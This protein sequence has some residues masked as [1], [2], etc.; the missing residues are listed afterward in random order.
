VLVAA[1]AAIAMTLLV[2]AG[3]LFKSFL[4]LSA[5]D[6]GFDPERLLT[7]RP[8]LAGATWSGQRLASFVS[9][10]DD[11]LARLPGVDAVGATNVVPFGAWSSAIRYRRADRSPDEPLLQAN[12]RTVTPGFFRAMGLRLLKGRLLDAR[13]T[14]DAPDVVV[15]TDSLAARTWPG[16]DPLGRQLVWGRTGR[17]KTVVG[18][19]SDLRDRGLDVAPRPTMFRAFPQLPWNDVTIMVRASGD[20]AGLAA[21]VRRAVQAAA[22]D[23]GVAIE[24]MDQVVSGVLR[25][26]R[27]NMLVFAAFALLALALAAVG[28]FGLVSYAVRQR[29]REIAIRVALGA[30][31]GSLLWTLLRD[32][33]ILVVSGGV[34]GL[35]GGVALSRG[36]AS[37]LYETGP[38]DPTAYVPMFLVLVVVGAAAVLVPARR[39][40]GVDPIAVLRHE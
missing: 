26:P 22:P 4:T 32:A 37:L 15:V 6:P 11:R 31:P 28:L 9:D 21:A 35:A 1:Q 10:L 36:L 2:G 5:V 18:V 38:V 13:D 19:V 34:A 14:A 25:Q 16:E 8:V 7:V 17:P 12:W 40:L 29:Q 24:P 33:A 39:A 30:R 27:T 23:V 20:P 3:L